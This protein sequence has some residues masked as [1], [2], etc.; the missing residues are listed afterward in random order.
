MQ[1]LV[2]SDAIVVSVVQ[3]HAA[4]AGFPLAAAADV[5]VAA[6][7]ARFSLGYT[8][9]GLSV[10]GGT[11]MLAHSLGLHRALRLALLDDA[12]TAEQAY[13][14][15]LVACVVPD[16]ELAA[17]AEAVVAQ[18]LCG[19][20][21]GQAATKRLLRGT[22]E[23]DPEGALKRETEAIRDNAGRPDGRE[24]VAAFLEKRPAVFDA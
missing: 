10:D 1:P 20:R 15:G 19:P 16:G 9:V 18:L 23:P 14:A 11:S 13:A 4:G 6:Q 24:G 8:K 3:G 7:T 2:R 21:E 5:V 17:T 22:V 12:L